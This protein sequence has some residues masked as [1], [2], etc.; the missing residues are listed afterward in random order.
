MK[1]IV[2]LLDCV[3]LTST[4][5]LPLTA[6]VFKPVLQAPMPCTFCMSPLSDT[7]NSGVLLNKPPRSSVLH[8]MTRK[9]IELSHLEGHLNSLIAPRGTR[10]E[11]PSRGAM[12]EDTQVGHSTERVPFASK[13][14]QKKKTFLKTE[15]SNTHI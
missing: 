13:T 11:E 4:L 2:Y 1:I 5:T 9:P 15:S 8:P 10:S 14:L 6:V 12:S 7:P 3:L